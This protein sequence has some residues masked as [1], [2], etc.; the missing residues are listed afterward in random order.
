MSYAEAKKK[1]AAYGVDA[2]AAIE[3]LKAVPV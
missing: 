2:E 3:R 1:Y